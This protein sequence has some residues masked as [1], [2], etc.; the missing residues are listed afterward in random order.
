MC[1][2]VRVCGRSAVCSISHIDSPAIKQNRFERRTGILH[3]DIS[4][5]VRHASSAKRHS[6]FDVL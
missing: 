1:L 2:C 6:T 3:L 5:P 4:I